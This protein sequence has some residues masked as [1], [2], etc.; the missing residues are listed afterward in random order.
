MGVP[1]ST[2]FPSQPFLGKPEYN[3][4]S[5][6]SQRKQQRPLSLSKRKPGLSSALPIRM[7]SCIFP[8]PVTKI[9]S[10]PGNVI[11]RRRSE[12]NLEKPKQLCWH[13]RLEELQAYSSAGE[14]LS[15]LEFP[16]ALELIVPGGL[17]QPL[18][19]AVDGNLHISSKPSPGNSIDWVGQGHHGLSEP[20]GRQQVTYNDVR[21]QARRVKQARERLAKALKADR[22]AREAEQKTGPEEKS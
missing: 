16:N 12:E 22:L 20:L 9:S 15:T 6:T 18:G 8:R 3:M 19:P 21:K 13:R 17:A 2:D 14:P 7:T 1:A 4:I 11:R 10:N 5:Q